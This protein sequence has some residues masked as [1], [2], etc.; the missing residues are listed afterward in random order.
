MKQDFDPTAQ[1]DQKRIKQQLA[2]KQQRTTDAKTLLD[3]RKRESSVVQEQL[4][5]GIQHDASLKMLQKIP[6]EAHITQFTE[7][8]E[9]TILANKSPQS[10]RTCQ[11][12]Q[13]SPTNAASRTCARTQKSPA[14][15]PRYV[16]DMSIT[17]KPGLAKSRYL[18]ATLN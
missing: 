17:V 5:M 7:T 2:I 6:E 12:Q 4:E 16:P 10:P 9:E 18:D 1:L 13:K 3:I 15:R 11:K 14:R 8:Q